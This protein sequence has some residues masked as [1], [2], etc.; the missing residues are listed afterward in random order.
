MV[1]AIAAV[2]YPDVAVFDDWVPKGNWVWQVLYDD[3]LAVVAWGDMIFVVVVVV[4][5]GVVVSVDL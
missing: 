5:S 4:C 3:V 2:V 1:L